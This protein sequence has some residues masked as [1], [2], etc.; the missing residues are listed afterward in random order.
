MEHVDGRPIDAYCDDEDLSIEDG[1]ELF[2]KVCSAVHYAHQNLVVH[3]D[4]KPSNVLVTGDGEPRLLDFGIAK[5]LNP[6]AFP[7]THEATT[8]GLRPMT[9]HYASPEQVS[10]ETITTVSDVYSLGVL[11]YRLLTGRL[12]H[13]FTG[14]TIR[15]IERVLS[16]EEPVKPS[17]AVT[18]EPAAGDARPQKLS[19]RL[20]GDLDNIVAKALHRDPARRYGSVEQLAEDVHRH[21]TG[22]RVA[23]RQDSFGYR[24]SVF[25]HRHRMAVGVAGLVLVLMTAF[26][27]AMTWQAA[28]TSRQRDRAELERDK[29]R[30][31]SAFLVELFMEED[32]WQ[33]PGSELTVRQVLDRGASRVERELGDQPEVRATLLDAIGSVYIHLGLNEQAA[34]HLTSALDTRRGLA[35][36]DPLELAD[37]LLHVATLFRRQGKPE[38]AE[39]LYLQALTLR[40][41]AAGEGDPGVAIVHR[42]LARLYTLLEP[43]PGTTDLHRPRRRRAIGGVRPHRFVR[44]WEACS[45]SVRERRQKPACP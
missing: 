5:L 3:R 37:S 4:I 29:A 14:L 8:T 11:L 6:D 44:D 38:D 35:A 21:L 32:P 42:S 41:E 31:V 28:Q 19:R 1:L 7:V 12:P 45:V 9:P 27:A 36:P 20:A 15:E 22:R 30:Q 25:L 18:R 40:R 2:R 33:A 39:A 34:P 10:G 24:M 17:V 13:R 26:A 23:A 16:E 43:I